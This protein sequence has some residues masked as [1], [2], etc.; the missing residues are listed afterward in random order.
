MKAKTRKRDKLM[1]TKNIA[2]TIILLL[3]SCFAL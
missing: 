3:L 1:K 2:F